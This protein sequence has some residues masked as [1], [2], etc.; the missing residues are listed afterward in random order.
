LLCPAPASGF[1]VTNITSNSAALTWNVVDCAKGYKIH[2]RVKGTT[3]WTTAQINSNIGAVSLTGLT[4]NKIYQ[5]RIAT[6]CKSDVVVYSSY[7]ANKQFTTAASFAVNNAIADA[8]VETRS[9]FNKVYPNPA[10]NTAVVLVTSNKISSYSFELTDVSGKV[11]QSKTG[12]LSREENKIV[13][14]VSNYTPGIY[15]INVID[16]EGKGH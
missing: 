5:W 8:R 3:A 12:K 15:L 7:S 6:K 2:Y 14:D 13:L 9:S 11:L 10:N 16:K 4:S 1:N